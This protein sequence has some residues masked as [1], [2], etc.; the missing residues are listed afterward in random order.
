MLIA[1]EAVERLEL[2]AGEGQLAVLVLA[3]EG[4]QPGAER[5]Q[6]GAPRRERPATNALVRPLAETRRPSDEL[7]A[8]LGEPLRDL[9]QLRVVEQAL[10]K[11]E[12]PLDVGLVRAGPDDLRPR[13][14]AHQQVEGVRE[15]R[16]ARAGLAGDRV[17]A[18]AEAQL[19]ALDQQQVLDSELEE[20]RSPF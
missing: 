9:R 7:R 2:G 11:L 19:G 20:H 13:L 5:L 3:V 4:E 1:G 12:D 17:Q 10:G 14:P 16:L 18:R 6:V 8:P 15:D